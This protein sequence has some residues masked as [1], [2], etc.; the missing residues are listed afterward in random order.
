MVFLHLFVHL[1]S[2]CHLTTHH[3]HTTMKPTRLGTKCSLVLPKT[4]RNYVSMLLTLSGR[5]FLSWQA[6]TEKDFLKTRIP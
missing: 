3:C 4:E 6:D 2:Y 5:L 1:H